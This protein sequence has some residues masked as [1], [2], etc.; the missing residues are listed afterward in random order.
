MVEIIWT[1]PAFVALEALSF[2]V[3]L[4]LFQKAEML[5]DFPEMGGPL[6]TN[7]R[8]YAKY[9][10]LVFRKSHRVIYESDEY[11]DSV[12][13]LA[14]QDCRQ[15]LPSARDLKRVGRPDE[16]LPLE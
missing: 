10:Q 16:D 4:G 2:T 8:A 1:S 15:K 3:A 7:K 11:D 9:R 6:P 14:I 5:K 12:C 13:I